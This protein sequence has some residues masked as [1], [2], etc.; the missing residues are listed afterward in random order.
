MA[1]VLLPPRTRVAS[2]QMKYV[3]SGGGVRALYTGSIETTAFGGDRL[4]ATLTLSPVGGLQANERA[5]RARL[6]AA[7]VGLRG[8]ANRIWM[9]DH[10]YTRRGSFPA[11][12]LHPDGT[13]IK[14]TGWSAANGTTLTTYDGILRITLGGSTAQPAADSS[15]TLIP[16]VP[17]CVRVFFRYGR[18]V[19]TNPAL[20]ITDQAVST[21]GNL[22][23]DGLVVIGYVPSAAGV[24]MRLYGGGSNNWQAGDFY[25]CLYASVARCALVDGGPNLLL[26]SDTPGGTSWQL[27]NVTAGANG[28]PGPDGL[29]DAYYIAETTANAAHYATQAITVPA[30]VADYTFSIYVQKPS[31]V[32]APRDWCFL[33]LQESTGGGNTGLACFFNIATG[34]VGTSTTLGAGWSNLRTTSEDCGNGWFR[35]SITG[36]KTSAATGLIA[37]IGSATADGTSGYAG[38]ASNIALL[39]WRATLSASSFPTRAVSTAASAAAATSDATSYVYLKGLPPST[40]GLLLPSDQVQIGKQLTNVVA[41]LDSN[42][43]GLGY[44]QVSPPLRYAPGDNDPVVIVDPMGR[45]VFSGDYPSWANQ[46]GVTT[47][48]DLE[49]EE[50]CRVS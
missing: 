29:S 8:K 10:S 36:R 32:P 44:L 49:F 16:N 34:A 43:A 26:R 27:T 47:T 33:Q 4:G 41:S 25:E 19:N 48:A 23:A 1:E 17:Y 39:T 24:T 18:G 37:Y 2:S 46:P 21:G 6:L 31:A 45:F 38:T 7:I 35:F 5:K 9:P 50:D 42:A 40:Q 28:T 11:T 14:G 22:G 3:D 20:Y 30:G 12:E 15:V 13:N